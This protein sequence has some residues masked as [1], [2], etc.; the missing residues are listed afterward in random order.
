[1]NLP[2][3]TLESIEKWEHAP[4]MDYL[5]KVDPHFSGVIRFFERGAAWD[6]FF[7][8]FEEGSLIGYYTTRG[9]TPLEEKLHSVIEG[10]EVEVRTFSPKEMEIARTL[11]GE[12]LLKPPIKIPELGRE[13]EAESKMRDFFPDASFIAEIK[14][15]RQFRENFHRRRSEETSL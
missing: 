12:Y 13:L 2:R 6:V 7:L 1:M 8:L 9:D 4:P 14:K 15:A 3:G 10:F 11:N 5:S